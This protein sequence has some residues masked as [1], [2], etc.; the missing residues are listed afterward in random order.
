MGRN[1]LVSL[2][3]SDGVAREDQL[4]GVVSAAFAPD[5]RL[6]V[7]RRNGTRSD[8]LVDGRVRFSGTGTFADPT[9][10]PDGRWVLVSWRNADQWL[11]V[12]ATGPRGVR[13]VANVT[14]QFDSDSPPR[15][16]GWSSP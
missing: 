11:F 10:S 6:A 16:A 5:G 4:P 3:G 13:A 7:I 2:R 12:R 8:V 9:W 15:I 14:R 1:R